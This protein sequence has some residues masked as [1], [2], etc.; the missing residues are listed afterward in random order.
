MKR[1]V[2]FQSF[3]AGK[4]SVGLFGVEV[5]QDGGKKGSRYQKKSGSL[6]CRWLAHWSRSHGID[7]TTVYSSENRTGVQRCMVKRRMHESEGKLLGV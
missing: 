4:T 6:P 7:R 1:K 2:F 3:V 5:R